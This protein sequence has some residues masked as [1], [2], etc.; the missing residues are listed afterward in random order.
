[1]TDYDGYYKLPRV[2]EWKYEP[3][4]ATAPQ[5]E[6]QEPREWDMKPIDPGSLINCEIDDDI[7][8]TTPCE[9]DGHSYE[10]ISYYD[11]DCHYFCKKCGD[12]KNVAQMV[13]DSYEEP[14]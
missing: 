14:A 13:R 3:D 6:P 2:P 1:M 9:R 7:T 10:A 4:Y 12:L 8:D 5:D 11:G